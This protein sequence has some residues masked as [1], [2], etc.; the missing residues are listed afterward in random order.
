MK[1]SWL[2][3]KKLWIISGGIF[4]KNNIALKLKEIEKKLLKKDFWKDK[5]IAKKTVKEKKIYEDI[6]NSYRISF[7][8]TN[9]LKDLFNL[10]AEE[11][12]EEILQDCDFKIDQLISKIKII[13]LFHPNPFQNKQ[14]I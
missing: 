1:K 4:E 14:L 12:N 10:A 6:T 3:L 13:V 9:N 5:I 2:K 11:K 7:N 8:E